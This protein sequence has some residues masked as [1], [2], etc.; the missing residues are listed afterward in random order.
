MSRPA[1]RAGSVVRW[2]PGEESARPPRW[3]GIVKKR[4]S[5]HDTGIK[6][7]RTRERPGV[8]VH[9]CIAVVALRGWVGRLVREGWWF[10]RCVDGWASGFVVIYVWF[11]CFAVLLSGP[12][13]FSPPLLLTRRWSAAFELWI[14]IYCGTLLLY[15]GTAVAHGGW[16]VRL[17]GVSTCLWVGA[18]VVASVR[19]WLIVCFRYCAVDGDHLSHHLLFFSFFFCVRP[20]SGI[21]RRIYCCTAVVLLLCCC[22]AI[23][24]RKMW[25]HGVG[26]GCFFFKSRS[27]GCCFSDFESGPHFLAWSELENRLVLFAHNNFQHRSAAVIIQQRRAHRSLSMIL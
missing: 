3:R 23:I 18:L 7:A 12:I 17:V 16:V 1:R 10:G 24:V 20:C 14:H 15:Q 27:V 5:Q 8:R 4:K 13:V 21:V 26:V 25:V 6:S 9:C 19:T 11:T 22:C 2:P